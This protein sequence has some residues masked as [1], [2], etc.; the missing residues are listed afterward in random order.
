[1]ATLKEDILEDRT[2]IILD[3][4]E[5]AEEFLWNST[6]ILGIFQNPYTAVSLGEGEAESSDPSARYRPEDT[7]GLAHDDSVTRVE[8]GV[9]YKVTGVEPDG[10]GWVIV[11]FSQV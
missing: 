3:T 11:T 5:F 1:M 6:T 10:K 7:V 9:V 4:D 8:T 2:E